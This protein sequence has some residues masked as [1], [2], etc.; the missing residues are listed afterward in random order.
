MRTTW[1]LVLGYHH[2][3][4]IETTQVLHLALRCVQQWITIDAGSSRGALG[5][6]EWIF[7]GSSS[8]FSGSLYL[9]V[10][11]IT[12]VRLLSWK[13]HFSGSRQR[14]LLTVRIFSGSSSSFSGCLYLP[15]LNVT[16]VRLLR[17]R[18]HRRGS[19]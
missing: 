6:E 17:W 16:R 9:P 14:V 12:R 1:L 13:L 3:A 18:L 11:N 5:L 8:I 4:V 7:S 15:V 10:M 19:Q 2:M